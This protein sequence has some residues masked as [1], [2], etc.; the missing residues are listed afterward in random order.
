MT[1]L[2]NEERPEHSAGEFSVDSS[3]MESLTWFGVRLTKHNQHQW[4][5]LLP[6]LFLL[7]LFLPSRRKMNEFLWTHCCPPSAA[8]AECGEKQCDGWEKK[9]IIQH[10]TNLGGKI[11]PR[12]HHRHPAF[13]RNRRVYLPFTYLVI[14]ASFSQGVFVGEIINCSVRLAIFFQWHGGRAGS[15]LVYLLA[16]SW[17]FPSMQTPNLHNLRIILRFVLCCIYPATTFMPHLDLKS[18]FVLV[19]GSSRHFRR[20]AEK[21]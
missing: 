9:A 12:G 4:F 19:R 13:T 7:L 11:C 16:D 3:K 8:E 15:E 5:H 17:C 18:G 2:L 20:S 10:Q 14:T 6:W 1:S 21:H